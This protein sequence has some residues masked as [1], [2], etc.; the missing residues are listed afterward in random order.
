M[1]PRVNYPWNIRGN[2]SIKFHHVGWDV[3]IVWILFFFLILMTG[4]CIYGELFW[5]EFLYFYRKICRNKNKEEYSNKVYAISY[6][7]HVTL[8]DIY[9]KLVYLE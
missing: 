1:E 7:Y 8:K 3:C 5:K 2:F 6:I 9:I 4:E